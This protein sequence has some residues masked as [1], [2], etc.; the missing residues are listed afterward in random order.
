MRLLLIED[1]EMIG[2]AVVT[3]LTQDGNV[4]E[5]L[6]D[7]AQ[8]LHY[9]SHELFDAVLLDLGLPGKDGLQVLRELRRQRN[10]TPIIVI[11]A[12]D[13]TASRVKGLDSGADDYVVKPFDLDE[14]A[15]RIRAVARRKAGRS[16]ALMTH[17]GLEMNPVTHEV[18]LDGKRLELSAREFAVLETLMEHPGAITPRQRIEDRLYGWDTE[19]ASNA[20]EVHI[21]HLRKKLGDGFI[22]TV[23]GMG[24]TLGDAG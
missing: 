18:T 23:R 24:Y 8:G 19:I 3:G 21:H 13:D 6:R 5:W 4:V 14:L 22:R 15:A 16:T 11:T 20:V 10:D 12:R 7:G 9:A 17:R 1:D 2:S